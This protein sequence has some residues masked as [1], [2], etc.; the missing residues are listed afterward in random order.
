MKIKNTASAK[1]FDRSVLVPFY[2]SYLQ[3]V[4]NIR[5]RYGVEKGYDTLMAVIEYGLYE[6][7]SGD[8]VIDEALRYVH[9]HI[10]KRQAERK[11]SYESYH[12][13]RS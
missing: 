8:P 3:P 11:R 12:Q 6:K 4:R 9:A 10:D 1:P 7:L 2:E 13:I 5:E